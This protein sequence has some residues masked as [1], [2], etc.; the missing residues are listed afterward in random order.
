MAK[1]LS[2]QTF[3]VTGTLEGYSRAGAKKEIEA[4][5][6]KVSGSVS[7]NTDCVVVGADPGSK[8]DKAKQLGIKTLN[9]AGFK[10]LL[11]GASKKVAKKKVTKKKATKKKATTKKA[12]K[13]KSTTKKVAKKKVAKKA[14][15]PPKA[16]AVDQEARKALLKAMKEGDSWKLEHADK[17]LKADREIVL[18]AVKQDGYALE[19]A[20]KSLKADRE[21]VL[22]A[23]KEEGLALEYAAKSLKADREIVLAAV[24]NNGNALEYAAKSLKADPDIVLAAAKANGGALEEAMLKIEVEGQGNQFYF[25]EISQQTYDFY[26][27]EDELLWNAAAEPGNFDAAAWRASDSYSRCAVEPQDLDIEGYY[28]ESFSDCV[29]GFEMGNSSLEVYCDGGS[30][31]IE[32]S[33]ENIKKLGINCKTKSVSMEHFIENKEGFVF[34]AYERLAG[35]YGELELPELSKEKTF[36][37]KK[38]SLTITNF[39]WSGNEVQLVTHLGYGNEQ[40]DSLGVPEGSGELPVFEL[41]KVSKAH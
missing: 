2:G 40:I 34:L 10:R 19:Y 11:G 26:K 16:E 8:A 39:K 9:E 3:V 14:A 38:L 32:L 41:L 33:E 22:K 6:G 37:P 25:S 15:T 17:S 24:K 35:T 13:K 29:I 20:A 7:A 28:D 21:V 30:Q 36:D 1:K 5:G 4:L 18:A 27:D 31:T 12:T 23:V